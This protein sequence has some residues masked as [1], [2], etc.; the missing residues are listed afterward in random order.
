MK[1][2]MN[3]ILSGML[4]LAVFAT[5][6]MPQQVQA[7]SVISVDPSAQY[8]DW[9]GWGTSLAWFGNVIG[10]WSDAERNAIADKLFSLEE[11]MGLN[12]IRYNIGGGENPS[13]DH[14]RPGAEIEGFQPSPG[15]WDWNADANQRW[16]LQAAKARGAN[17]FEAFSNSPPYWM[18]NSQCA[19]GSI[20]G[21]QN[22]LQ[23]QYFAPFGDYLA[24]VVKHFKD[25]WDIEFETVEPVNESYSPFWF[26]YG[27]QEG[28]HFD[29]SAQNAIIKD[30]QNG[31]I[32]RGI[33]GTT[34]AASDENNIDW[35]IDSFHSYDSTAKSY[36]SRI[37]T[38]TYNGSRRVELHNVAKSNG[39]KLWMSEVGMGGAGGHNHHSIAPALNLSNQILIDVKQMLPSAWVYWQ[40]VEDEGN[41][42]SSNDNWG[43]IHADFT[44][45]TE[46]WY[47]TKK[48]Y[49]MSNY[50]KFIRP[51][52]KLIA[53]DDANSL[54]AY[55]P[56]TGTTVIVT[57]NGSATDQDVT[58]DLSKF[59]SIAGSVAPY[60][61]SAA[62]DLARLDDI[63]IAGHSF[64][65][66]AKANSITTLVISGTSYAGGAETFD[67]NDYYHIVNVNS[68]KL[69]DV[70][71]SSTNDDVQLNQWEKNNTLSQQWKFV[72]VGNGY[73]KI[74]NR[75]SGKVAG[76]S[77]SSTSDSAKVLQWSDLGIFDQEW[78]I[79]NIGGGKYMF[80]NRNS[81]KLLDVRGE[82]TDNGASI[83][84]Y[85]YHNGLN[86]QWRL[87][88][89]Q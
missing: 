86:Q 79:Q 36:I 62:E 22:N 25:E 2:W 33:T 3:M 55:D 11:G 18:T 14:M 40:A 28:A 73:Y 30:T 26:A 38:H 6:A 57:T 74:V 35:M 78:E 81:G 27:K 24:E 89:V 43:I 32:A 82:S 41:M 88:K 60:R 8:A 34:V 87:E 75:N 83:V 56:A 21:I 85:T 42:V 39:K 68:G 48:F 51:G 84:Q 54:A 23:T 5:L 10:G 19:S 50:S 20:L 65:A 59:A 45:G 46:N 69:L 58:F 37:N 70:P 52:Y 7:A 12:V 67:P 1:R 77:A 49:A 13:H 15:V 4:A 16:M 9:E 72:E 66:T 80:I 61:T 71:W 63:S 64:T 29:R 47:L 44:G 53:I 76:V 31:L 17:K